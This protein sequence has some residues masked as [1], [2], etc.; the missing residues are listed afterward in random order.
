M[1]SIFVIRGLVGEAKRVL[2]VGDSWGRDYWSLRLLGEEVYALD[3]APQKDI[4]H[5]I[6]ADIS[7][8]SAT[9]NNDFDAVV[10]AEVIEHLIEVSVAFAN[11]RILRPEGRLILTVP[12]MHDA[13]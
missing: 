1:S 13:F 12:F 5:L 8:P 3:I 2:V 11:P 4:D 9:L 10:M 6:L 7:Q